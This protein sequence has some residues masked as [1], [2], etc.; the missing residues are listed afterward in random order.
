MN[1]IKNARESMSELDD[2]NLEITQTEE[3]KE[4][5]MKKM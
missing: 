5:R 1:E 2:R 4:K 3:N